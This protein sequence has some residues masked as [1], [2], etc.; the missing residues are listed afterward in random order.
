MARIL[1]FTALGICHIWL[2]IASESPKLFDV[3]VDVNSIEIQGDTRRFW[4]K[5]VYAN[6]HALGDREVT[7]GN[8]IVNCARKTWGLI[9]L[10]VLDRNNEPEVVIDIP[11][12]LGEVLMIPAR[13]GSVSEAVMNFVCTVK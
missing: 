7:L 11:L 6:E 9:M 1:E 12:L 10:V 4:E 5:T 13:S 2:Y 8:M 3:Y